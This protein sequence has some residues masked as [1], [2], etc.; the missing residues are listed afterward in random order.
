M[1]Q[2]LIVWY[3]NWKRTRKPTTI[4]HQATGVNETCSKT[5]PPGLPPIRL[6]RD[7]NTALEAIAS[8]DGKMQIDMQDFSGRWNIALCQSWETNKPAALLPPP[9]N[10]NKIHHTALKVLQSTKTDQQWFA[11]LAYP[12]HVKMCSFERTFILNIK[13]AINTQWIAK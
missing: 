4:R 11:E 5:I 9:P 12:K 7:E 6:E 10:N 8:S 2:I 3:I 1:S 13:A